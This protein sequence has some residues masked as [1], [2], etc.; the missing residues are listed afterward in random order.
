MLIVAAAVY[1][2]VEITNDGS[3][4]NNVLALG[5]SCALVKALFSFL[6][7]GVGLTTIIMAYTLFVA[8]KQRYL[9]TVRDNSVA[10]ASPHT[11]D[12]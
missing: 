11:A 4:C 6:W 12:M 7:I 9:R 8:F 2:T 1:F 5:F 10:A 3:L